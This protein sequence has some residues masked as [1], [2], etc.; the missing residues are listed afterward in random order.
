M[1]MSEYATTIKYGDK[2]YH[3]SVGGKDVYFSSS[4]KTGGMKLKG[5]ECVN[6]QLRT[7]SNSKPATEFQLA[8]AI[9]RSLR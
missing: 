4:N 3:I 7:T 8:Q 9:A 2:S 5:I 6:N 1:K